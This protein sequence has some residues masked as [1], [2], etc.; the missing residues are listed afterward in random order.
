MRLSRIISVLK[1]K[2]KEEDP[3]E[4]LNTIGLRTARRYWIRMVSR[5]FCADMTAN[6]GDGPLQLDLSAL[7]NAPR[8]P[9]GRSRG[10]FSEAENSTV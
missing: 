2:K 9:Q 10:R 1:I 5:R 3:A 8:G 7:Q 6:G 4:K